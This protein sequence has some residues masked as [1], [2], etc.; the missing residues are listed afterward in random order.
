MQYRHGIVHA[1]AKLA[2]AKRGTVTIEE[3]SS[4][5]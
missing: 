5:V 3:T 2:P 1:P 4:D